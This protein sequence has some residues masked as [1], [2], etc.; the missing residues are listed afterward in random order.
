MSKNHGEG[1]SEQI[2]YG[3]HDPKRPLSIPV[4][5]LLAMLGFENRGRSRIN[6]EDDLGLD[7]ETNTQ[8]FS[9]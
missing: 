6:A 2:R 9:D 8:K 4:E 3:S 5:R 1:G 7:I